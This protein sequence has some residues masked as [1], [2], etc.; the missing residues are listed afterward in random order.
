MI[1]ARGG[2]GPGGA[3]GGG[4]IAIYY[5]VVTLSTTSIIAT[6]GKSGTGATASYNG[7]AGTVYLKSNMLPHGD[8]IIDNRST[9]SNDSSTPLR[10]IGGGV[11][12]A[13]TSTS[14]MNSSAAWTAGALKGLQ[15]SPNTNQATTF[16]VIDN[17]ATTLYIDPAGGDLTQ[18]SVVGSAYTGV[19][20]F[21]SMNVLGTSKVRCNDHVVVDSGLTIDGSGTTFVTGDV[22]A[23]TITLTNGGVLTHGN[24]TTTTVYSLN[25]N[26]TTSLAIDSS[27]KIDVTG[28]GYL[29]GSSGGNSSPTGRTYGN[30]TAGGSTQNNSGN[31]GSYGGLG[32]IYSG[33]SVNTVYGD[34]MNPSEVGSGGG[35]GLYCPYYCS[36]QPGGNGG[37]LVKI[38]AGTLQVDGS[39]IAD[40]GA[41]TA[42]SYNGGGGSGGGVNIHVS[43]LSG[44][45]MITARGGA[46]PGGAGG[47]GRIAIYYS[48]RT[49]FLGVETVSG[50]L[51][52]NG[53]V[54]GRNG[55]N[56]TMQW[57]LK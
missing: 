7:G 1:T 25:L 3:G 57:I 52:G 43:T 5:D 37:G 44:T 50:G 11:I 55:W 13:V 54:T 49:E 30:T 24:T 14:L 41:G 22:T 16:T 39:I 12:S 20:S 34:L 9:S 29:G 21:N 51:S 26:A 53:L 2:A 28:R 36:N 6:G 42:T 45:G 33:G 56:G 31:G 27:S 48:D 32:G 46:G 18:V 10:A 8:L 35:A 23:N 19:Y 15:V 4:R 40:G 38:T 17:T 47:G